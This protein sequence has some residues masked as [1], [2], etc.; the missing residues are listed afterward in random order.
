MLNNVEWEQGQIPSERRFSQAEEE[1][2]SGRRINIHA[3]SEGDF[4]STRAL[5]SPSKAKPDGN[6]VLLRIGIEVGTAAL[7]THCCFV[8]LQ[9][10]AT[11]STYV[12]EQTGQARR[13]RAQR[14]PLWCT[15][16]VT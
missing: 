6:L 3:S 13:R 16:A 11:T 5:I 8:S 14:G 15:A 12:L 9:M 7:A 1:Y 2:D 4:F 10:E